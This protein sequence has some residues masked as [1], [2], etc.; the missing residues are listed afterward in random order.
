MVESQMETTQSFDYTYSASKFQRMDGRLG[1]KINSFKKKVQMTLMVAGTSNHPDINWEETGRTF[2]AG[3]P[4]IPD[5]V[6]QMVPAPCC[7]H[8][9]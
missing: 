8:G 4:R 5:S 1:E 9:R 3:S 2:F 7:N 6:R